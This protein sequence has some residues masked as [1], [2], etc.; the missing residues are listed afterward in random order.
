[1][2]DRNGESNRVCKKAEVWVGSW[3]PEVGAVRPAQ[4]LPMGPL[5]QDAGLSAG[6]PH[7]CALP[8]P[9]S[10][11]QWKEFLAETRSHVGAL[12]SGWKG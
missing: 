9:E 8:P 11:S 5:C 7:V 12:T 4:M 6:S 1:M 10:K 3:G 2:L